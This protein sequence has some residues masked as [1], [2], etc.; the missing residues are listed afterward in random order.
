MQGRIWPAPICSAWVVLVCMRFLPLLLWL[1]FISLGA[2]PA[3]EAASPS[4]ESGYADSSSRA[5]VAMIDRQIRLS[6]GEHGVKPSKVATDGEWCRRVFLD[7]LGRVPTVKEL[8]S[9]VS[10]RSR[11]KRLELVDRLLGPEY[12]RSEEGV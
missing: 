3:A 10:E 12:L 2:V 7:L 8:D 6:W 11:T 5:V 9:Y 4:V 1:V